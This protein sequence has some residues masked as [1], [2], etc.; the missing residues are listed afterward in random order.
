MLSTYLAED[1]SDFLQFPLPLP[2]DQKPP[3]QARYSL[4]TQPQNTSI[5]KYFAPRAQKSQ[6]QLLNLH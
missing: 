3:N 2:K 6:E 1:A 5:S 4:S